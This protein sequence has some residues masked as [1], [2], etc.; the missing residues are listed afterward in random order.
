MNIDIVLFIFIFNLSRQPGGKHPDIGRVIKETLQMR[1]ANNDLFANKNSAFIELDKVG[2]KKDQIIT[3]ARHNNGRTA[4]IVAN[5]NPNRRLTGTILVPGL[6]ET[7]EL[8]N[9][10]PKY[11][12]ESSEF[13]VVNGELRVDL[14]PAGAYVF[15]IDTPNIMEDRKNN[16]YMQRTK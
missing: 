13:Q 16:A 15:E 4:L 2:D 1:N 6:K 9:L 3:Y 14:A 7:Q 12:E 5:K 8:K 10:A 11:G